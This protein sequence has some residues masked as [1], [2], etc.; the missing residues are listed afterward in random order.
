MTHQNPGWSQYNKYL[1]S[2]DKYMMDFDISQ[3]INN[4]MWSKRGVICAC[5]CLVMTQP[6]IAFHIIVMS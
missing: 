5:E 6:N 4:V 1:S 2:M 3:N